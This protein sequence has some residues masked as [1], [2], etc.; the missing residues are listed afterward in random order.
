MYPFCDKNQKEKKRKEKASVKKLKEKSPPP[1]FV[2][3]WRARAMTIYMYHYLQPPV[4]VSIPPMLLTCDLHWCMFKILLY[5]HAFVWDF[6]LLFFDIRDFF[7]IL[8]LASST[9]Y[10]QQDRNFYQNSSFCLLHI[11]Q[12]S[13]SCCH[14]VAV[15][16]MLFSLMSS[17]GTFPLTTTLTGSLHI[18]CLPSQMLTIT[19]LKAVTRP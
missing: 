19:I 10:F 3:F 6:L 13:C 5:C 12:I 15:P 1:S 7:P 9:M 2:T 11:T 14:S 4:R 8:F 18:Q 16:N 17:W